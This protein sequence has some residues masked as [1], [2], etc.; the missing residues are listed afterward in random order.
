MT[1]LLSDITGTSFEQDVLKSDLPVLVDFWAPWCH[2]CRSMVPTLARLA[3][4]Y[5]GR[6]KIVKVNAD[7][8]KEIL[9]RFTVRGLP[10]VILFE[11]GQESAR[12]ISPSTIRLNVLFERFGAPD[13]TPDEVPGEIPEPYLFASGDPATISYEGRPECKKACLASLR[14]PVNPRDRTSPVERMKGAWPALGEQR[15]I[16]APL[17]H[18]LDE[19]YF[20]CFAFRPAF[21]PRDPNECDGLAADAVTD[22]IRAIPVG[23][24]LERIMGRFIHDQLHH[25]QHGMLRAAAPDDD[26]RALV[27]RLATLHDKELIDANIDKAAYAELGRDIVVWTDEQRG[28]DQDQNS[29]EVRYGKWLESLCQP[30]QE[31]VQHSPQILVGSYRA[32]QEG[33]A[34]ARESKDADYEQAQ[35]LANARFETVREVLGPWPNP[36]TDEFIARF[37]VLNANLIARD[38]AVHPDLFERIDRQKKESEDQIDQD[39]RETVERFVRLVSDH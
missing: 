4:E 2:P 35:Q 1:E 27:G 18:L 6:V 33:D 8:N 26:A 10:T 34:A 7:D 37:K 13:R 36:A 5:A 14:T 38:R 23:I 39:I 31:V 25:P 21:E 9:S 24:R 11:N 16:L 29:L 17:G 20:R 22:I 32:I 15:G 30:L 3:G 28:G 19:V 12:I